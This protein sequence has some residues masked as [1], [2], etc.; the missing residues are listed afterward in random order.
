MTIV[1]SSETAT[2]NAKLAANKEIS[3]G[4][5][6]KLWSHRVRSGN[7]NNTHFLFR[8]IRDLKCIY[9]VQI[10]TGIAD[11]KWYGLPWKEELE[12]T[13]LYVKTEI[14]EYQSCMEKKRKSEDDAYNAEILRTTDDQY[15]QSEKIR[16]HATDMSKARVIEDELK[17]KMIKRAIRSKESQIST[18]MGAIRT[19]LL[20]LEEKEDNKDSAKKSLKL[21]KRWFW[22]KGKSKNCG[23]KIGL[24]V[25]LNTKDFWRL[26]KSEHSQELSAI[27]CLRVMLSRKFFNFDR[28][29]LLPSNELSLAGAAFHLSLG[30][31]L[32]F[33]IS[34]FHY[35]DLI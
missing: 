26:L 16:Q 33:S 18:A 17:H 20:A 32:H 10:T 28:K 4:L 3:D 19:R 6:A 2:N 30:I 5:L 1:G 31:E 27:P 34:F 7:F 22:H 11:W 15:E 35:C 25:D 23:Y 14:A 29:E 8:G 9:F 24:K 21:L 13:K 12:K